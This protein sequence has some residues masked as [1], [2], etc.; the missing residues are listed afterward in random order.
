ML[1]EEIYQFSYAW[2]GANFRSDRAVFGVSRDEYYALQLHRPF[3]IEFSPV[4]FSREDGTMRVYGVVVAP[5][6]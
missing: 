6:R 2:R 3:N 5:V 1:L 4:T